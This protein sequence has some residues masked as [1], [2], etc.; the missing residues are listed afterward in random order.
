MTYRLWV[1]E[2]RTI[3]VRIWE[4][5]RV[6]VSLRLSNQHTWGPP[7]GLTEEPI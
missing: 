6:E 3:L 1:N 5:G 2:T 4:D 7:I